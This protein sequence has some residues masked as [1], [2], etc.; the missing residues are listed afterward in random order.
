MHR[1]ERPLRARVRAL[2]ATV[3]RRGDVREG[4]RARTVKRGVGTRG[5]RVALCAFAACISA[6]ACS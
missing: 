2:V 4:G 3:V 1:C 6:I 5:G